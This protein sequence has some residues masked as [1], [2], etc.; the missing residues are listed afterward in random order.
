[1]ARRQSDE[2]PSRAI[3]RSFGSVARGIV[4]ARLVERRLESADAVSALFRRARFALAEMLLPAKPP[5]KI[6]IS[7]I[8]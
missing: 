7:S 4:D 3:F 1:M 6:A 5:R 2:P 8:A